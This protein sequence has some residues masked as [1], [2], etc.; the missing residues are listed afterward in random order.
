GGGC[1]GM[2]DD[3]DGVEEGGGMEVTTVVARGGEDRV[4]PEMRNVLCFGRKTRRK[5]FPAA[6]AW[7]PAAA[8]WWPDILG[9]REEDDECVLFERWK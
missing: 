3:D 2:D 1:G 5:T 8:G 6:T 7:W 9:E 4:D